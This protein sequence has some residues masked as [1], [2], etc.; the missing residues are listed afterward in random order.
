MSIH[1]STRV[2][3]MGRS[4]GLLFLFVIHYHILSCIR[5]K[6]RVCRYPQVIRLIAAI[7]RSLSFLPAYYRNINTNEHY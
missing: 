7:M 2:S 5:E 3:K 4:V 6:L 1:V